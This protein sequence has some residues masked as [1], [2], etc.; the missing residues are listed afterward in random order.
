MP[1]RL[2]LSKSSHLV[3]VSLRNES[4]EVKTIFDTRGNHTTRVH[5]SRMRTA[6]SS[7]HQPGGLR[8][9]MLG[10][11]PFVGLETPPGQTPQAPLGW[12]L[13]TC[14][15]CWDTP[16]RPARHVGIPPARHAGIQPL[17]CGQTDTCKNITFVCGR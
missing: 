6:R 7:S 17:P 4:K 10:Y 8:Q 1:D 3:G 16:R 2:T 9:C 12:G 11:P 15:A 5:S 13:E 14:K